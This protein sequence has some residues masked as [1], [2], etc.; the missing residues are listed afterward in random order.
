MLHLNRLNALDSSCL[1][2][3]QTLKRFMKCK[4]VLLSSFL[5]GKRV[6]FH[7][8]VLFMLRYNENIIVIVKIIYL[9]V[10][11]ISQFLTW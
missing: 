4:T 9:Y 8:N 2:L 11:K 7:Q 1:L 5:F 10:F 6:I 3:R